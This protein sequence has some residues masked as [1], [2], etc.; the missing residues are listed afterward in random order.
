[1]FVDS[2]Y[3]TC[4]YVEFF[5]NKLAIDVVIACCI[6][7]SLS[8][9]LILTTLERD[10]VLPMIATDIFP[11]MA[12]CFGFITTRF[13]SSRPRTDEMRGRSGEATLGDSAHTQ[14][15]SLTRSPSQSSKGVAI[16]FG[17]I[18]EDREQGRELR[19]LAALS[20]TPAKQRQ[21]RKEKSVRNAPLRGPLSSLPMKWSV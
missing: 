8:P 5:T 10:R 20:R 13:L 18:E 1:M 7:S 6:F 14:C 17:E 12:F 16:S 3:G 4:T 19:M 9:L 11:I 21:R 15:H 2:L